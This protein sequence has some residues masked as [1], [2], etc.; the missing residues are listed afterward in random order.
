MVHYFFEDALDFERGSLKKI[1]PINYYF[2]FEIYFLI[3]IFFSLE[4]KVKIDVEKEKTRTLAEN[5]EN[6]NAQ[7]TILKESIQTHLQ[8]KTTIGDENEKVIMIFLS[9]F[10]STFFVRLTFFIRNLT[11]I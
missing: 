2:F 7:I 1:I 9:F 11:Q 4:L 5:V 10:S 8:S 3:V 6:L